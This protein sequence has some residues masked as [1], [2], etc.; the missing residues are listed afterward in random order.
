MAGGSEAG[1]YASWPWLNPETV[2]KH[3]PESEETLK[4]HSQNVRQGYRST[5]KPAKRRQKVGTANVDEPVCP[6]I[7][8]DSKHQDV[9]MC[10]FDLKNEM[11]E[12]I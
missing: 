7:V 6:P 2:R 3:F 4:G 8:A 12:K 1:N 10:T 11:E 5:T 9:V